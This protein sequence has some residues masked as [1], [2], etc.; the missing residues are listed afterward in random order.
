MYGF[1]LKA[2]LS[3][4]SMDAGS[5]KTYSQ[6]ISVKTFKLLHEERRMALL[7]GM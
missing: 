7:I 4:I 3:F 6:I 2:T 5:A 1:T